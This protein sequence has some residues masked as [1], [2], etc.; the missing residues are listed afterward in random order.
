[1]YFTLLKVQKFFEAVYQSFISM[2]R[3]I[4]RFRFRKGFE[5]TASAGESVFVLANGPSLRRDLDKYSTQLSS[6]TTMGVNLFMLSEDFTR[7]KPVYYIIVDVV[8]LREQTLERI[9]D[10][11]DRML[12]ALQ[13]KLDWSM[14]LFLP[15]EG[16]NSFFHR[17]LVSAG[18]PVSIIFF[19][20]TSI[21]G[22]KALRHRMYSR[23][24]GMPP[25]QNVLIGAL[26]AAIHCGFKRIYVLGADHSWH[27]GIHIEDSGEMKITDRHFYNLKGKKLPKH[28]GDSLEQFMIH[29]YFNELSRTFKSHILVQDYAH[30][31]GVEILNASSVSYIDAYR[32]I[33]PENIPWD[34]LRER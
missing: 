25:P 18:L 19:N 24:W 29:D 1:M 4:L 5:K 30:S 21:D 13:E 6:C 3:V 8:I 9:R 34:H 14:T 33:K 32:K 26:M 28:H 2:L 31:K 15:V 23:G 10:S 12:K 22:L 27:E 11:R 17:Q 16:K 7:V 20:R